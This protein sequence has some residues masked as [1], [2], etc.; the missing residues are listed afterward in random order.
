LYDSKNFDNT[1]YNLQ[2]YSIEPEISY[3]LRS[4]LRITAGYKYNSKTND[5]IYGGEVYTAQ[6]INGN[7]KYNILLNTSLEGKFTYTNILYD[8]KGTGQ[9]NS[10]VSYIILDGLLPGKNYL[11]NLDFTKKLGSSL[12]LSIQYEGRKP[13]EGRTVHTGRASL[14][15]I[16]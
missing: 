6:S 5:P 12:E 8:T 13:G 11:W 7:V 14:R 4:S 1:N 10:P 2:Q 3:T 9:V 15:A 16:L